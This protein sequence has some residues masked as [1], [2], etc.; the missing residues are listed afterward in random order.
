MKLC[1]LLWLGLSVL[2]SLTEGGSLKE[3]NEGKLENV[4]LQNWDAS[5]LDT[6]EVRIINFF[7]KFVIIIVIYGIMLELRC[8]ST[9]EENFPSSE[10]LW[11]PCEK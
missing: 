5:E 4:L 9:T 6:D 3:A 11:N 10:N 1:C 7:V 8:L 2:C